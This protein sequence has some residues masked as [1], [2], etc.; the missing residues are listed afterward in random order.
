MLRLM[1]LCLQFH[2]FT[3]GRLSAV[4][5]R[6]EKSVVFPKFA[7]LLECSIWNG[8]KIIRISSYSWLKISSTRY[9]SFIS[10]FVQSRK[11]SR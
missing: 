11:V 5:S 6:E 2:V 7:L 9:P 1:D 10:C 3:G 8:W 4:V